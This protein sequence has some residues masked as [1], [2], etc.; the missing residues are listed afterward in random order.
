MTAVLLG[1]PICPVKD[2]TS[3]YM[4]FNKYVIDGVDINPIGF[5]CNLEVL[6]RGHYTTFTEVPF[7]FVDRQAGQSKFGGNEI[8][9]YLVQLFSL[10]WYWLKMRPTR[11]RVE[12]TKFP[13]PEA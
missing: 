8:W 9:N 12:Y 2:V 10:G 5:K 11:K 6:V 13:Y 7:T 1:R 4:L 3:G